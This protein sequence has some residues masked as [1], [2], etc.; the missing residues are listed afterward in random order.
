TDG[1]AGRF[2]TPGT[3]SPDLVTGGINNGTATFGPSIT[4]TLTGS[5]T[6]YDLTN[7]VIY[8]GWSDASHDQQK[9]T[10]YY[11]TVASPATFNQLTGV[12]FN[13][14]LPGTVQSATR[15]TL[16][17]TNGVLAKNVA[18]VKID[19]NIL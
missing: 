2:N 5:A 13:P 4:Y 15:V 3:D 19:F 18:A 16:M 9:Y 10:V 6:G 8:G 1:K 11:S 14:T 12:D 17:A 7:I